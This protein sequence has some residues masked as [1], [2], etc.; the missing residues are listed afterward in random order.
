[1]TNNSSPV[2]LSLIKDKTDFNDFCDHYRAHTEA[3]I[4]KH[5][6][7]DTSRD[8]KL[9][10]AMR[11]GVLGGGKRV[12]ALLAF[13]AAQ[14]VGKPSPMTDT[15]A[16]ALE[17]IHAYSLIH[18]DLPAMDDD[19]LRR[20]KPS[21]HIAYGEATAILAGD[22]L[23]TTAAE[24]MSQP[25]EGVTALTQLQMINIL[26]GASGKYGMVA[27]QSI[28]LNAMNQQ[29][30]LDELINMHRLKTGALIRASVVL[31]AKSAYTDNTGL[32]SPLFEYAEAIGLAFQIQDD[33][34]DVTGDTDTLGKQQGADAA[35]NKPTFVSLMGLE[36]A[37]QKAQ[38]LHEQALAALSPFGEK[39]QRL[40][41][42]ANYI[43]QRRN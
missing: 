17:C 6:S 1:M 11:Y 39:A 21:C 40:K 43:I 33:I 5:L 34:L 18:D 28:D 20:G 10:E 31:G 29:L 38:T 36:Q 13:A 30:S 14:A 27:G 22:A 2:K 3:L 9:L 41:Q 12:R 26:T 23:Q 35:L 19:D 7:P 37:Q 32:L 24:I 4:D 8:E 25:H 16:V 42:L 15:T